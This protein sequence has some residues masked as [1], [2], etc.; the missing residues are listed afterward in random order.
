MIRFGC[1]VEYHLVYSVHETHF[2]N[3]EGVV[4]EEKVR[5]EGKM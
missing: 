4:I 5:R 3:V 2:Y 1:I